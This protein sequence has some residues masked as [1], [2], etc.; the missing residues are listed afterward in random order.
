MWAKNQEASSEQNPSGETGKIHGRLLEVSRQAMKT[1]PRRILRHRKGTQAPAKWFPGR[2]MVTQWE[3][4]S[5]LIT[6][7]DTFTK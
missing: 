3:A 6:I 5:T 1:D 4:A 7:D 2:R